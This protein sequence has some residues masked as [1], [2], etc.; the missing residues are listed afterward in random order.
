MGK[1]LYDILGVDENATDEEIKKAYK[2]KAV[3]NH[4]DKEG[5]SND[6]MV[7]VTT[8]YMV[9]KDKNRRDHYNKTGQTDLH[10][11]DKRFGELIQQ[12][13]IKI[14]EE[15]DVERYDLIDLFK[16]NL[17]NMQSNGKEEKKKLEKQLTKYNK[18]LKRLQPKKDTTSANLFGEI[19]KRNI[20][21]LEDTI[22]TYENDIK[23]LDEALEVVTHCDYKFEVPETKKTKSAF[24]SGKSNNSKKD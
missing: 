9:L 1:E 17:E 3:E 23:F 12:I 2:K 14:I 7:A 5:G 24:E 10:G 22:G 16:Q 19:I 4:P 11:F 13:F 15:V 8:A 18:A 20:M 21:R 6:K